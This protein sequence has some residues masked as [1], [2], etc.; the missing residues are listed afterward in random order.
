MDQTKEEF[1]VWIRQAMHDNKSVA[2]QELYHFLVTCF[3]RAD[4]GKIGKVCA[5]GF[6]SLVEE[7]AAMPR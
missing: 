3:V 4:T 6:D 7:A 1:I 5:D 2:Y